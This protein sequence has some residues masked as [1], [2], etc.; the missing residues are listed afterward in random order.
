MCLAFLRLFQ[1]WSGKRDSNSRP[2]PWQGRALPT[3]L[4]PRSEAILAIY[5]SLSRVLRSNHSKNEQLET[6]ET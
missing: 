2:R 1:I 6:D 5:P 3:E 4:F